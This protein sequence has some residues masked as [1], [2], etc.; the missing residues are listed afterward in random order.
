[1][2][3]C[4]GELTPHVVQHCMLLLKRD[5]EAAASGEL[6]TTLILKLAELGSDGRL[7]GNVSR[8]FLKQLGPDSCLRAETIDVPL[9]SQVD[10]NIK[11]KKIKKT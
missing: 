8:D 5:L 4:W 11:N 10:G 2:L 6:D 3:V 9:H 1:M 7:S